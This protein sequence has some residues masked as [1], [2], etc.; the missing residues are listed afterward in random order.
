[1]QW[2]GYLTVEL[3]NNLIMLTAEKALFAGVLLLCIGA[4]AQFKGMAPKTKSF[5]T[6]VGT[7]N[8]VDEMPMRTLIGIVLG[9]TSTGLFFIYAGIRIIMDEIE[10]GRIRCLPLIVSQGDGSFALL[11]CRCDTH[12]SARI[13]GVR[14]GGLIP[15]WAI[16]CSVQMQV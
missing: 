12:A 11:G 1:M 5:N 10:R 14:C 7:Y 15:Q 13:T 4:E 6:E 9:F 16:S 3:F 2:N 8:S